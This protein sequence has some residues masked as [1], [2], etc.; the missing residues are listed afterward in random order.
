MWERGGQVI[1]SRTIEG[2]CCSCVLKSLEDEEW[3]SILEEDKK[4]VECRETY[5]NHD[6]E[7][8][9]VKVRVTITIEEI[10]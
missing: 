6:K 8:T 4:D 9:Q 7:G 2:W 10:E 3:K 1:K 5:I